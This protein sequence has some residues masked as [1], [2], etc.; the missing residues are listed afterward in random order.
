MH[1][2]SDSES[3]SPCGGTL[4][5]AFDVLKRIGKE[6]F[7]KILIAADMEGITG[8]V[9]AGQRDSTHPEYQG[10]APYD[11]DVN[12]AIRACSTPAWTKWSSATATATSRNIRIEELDARARLNSGSPSPFSMVQGIDGG[13]GRDLHRLSSAVGHAERRAGSTWSSTCVADVFLNGSRRR[14]R[15][16]RPRGGSFRRVRHDDF[17]DQTA[18][19]R[20]STCSARWRRRW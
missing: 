5:Q 14:D 7:M 16:Q 2:L 15:P 9:H 18:C 8:V 3:D 13:V 19:A 10:F 20:R 6:P 1:S 4:A 11:A 17:G 12:A